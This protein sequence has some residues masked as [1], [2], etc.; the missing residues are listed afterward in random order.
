MGNK[1]T[2]RLHARRRDVAESG[3]RVRKEK[4]EPHTGKWPMLGKRKVL[5]LA[6]LPFREP[7]FKNAHEA[8]K[9]INR[10]CGR[11]KITKVTD[12]TEVKGFWVGR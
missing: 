8:Q 1:Y 6:L 11:H 3:Y 4:K 2:W 5:G 10:F 12:I 9:V 7:T